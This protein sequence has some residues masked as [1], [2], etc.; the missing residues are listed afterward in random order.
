MIIMWENTISSH[1][2]LILL[3]HLALVHLFNLFDLSF[4]EFWLF[5]FRCLLKYTTMSLC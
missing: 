3:S 4:S 5:D 2:V 1:T